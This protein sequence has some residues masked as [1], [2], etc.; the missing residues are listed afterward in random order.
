MHGSHYGWPVGPDAA[1]GLSVRLGH[2]VPGPH[3]ALVS[4][5]EFLTL[6][7][8]TSN[9]SLCTHPQA[10]HGNAMERLK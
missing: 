9:Q 2:I 5:L 4:V 7:S 1:V 3:A 8:Q 10:C 6:L